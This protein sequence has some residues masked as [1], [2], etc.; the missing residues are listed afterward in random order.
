MRP[1]SSRS[2]F[3]A[4]LDPSGNVAWQETLVGEQDEACAA[5]WA[6]GAGG[7]L[8]IGNRYQ[9]KTKIDVAFAE[10]LGTGGAWSAPAIA[11]TGGIVAAAVPSSDPGFVFLAEDMLTSDGTFAVELWRVRA[12]P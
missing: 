10:H 6:D 7:A 2:E 12:D 1:P 11:A 9:A 3:V 8:V 4:R 5:L